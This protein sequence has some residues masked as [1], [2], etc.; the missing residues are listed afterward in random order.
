M[1]SSHKALI[2]NKVLILLFSYIYIKLN[3]I[4]YLLYY[5]DKL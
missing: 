4:N 5:Y 1:V 3:K 2:I